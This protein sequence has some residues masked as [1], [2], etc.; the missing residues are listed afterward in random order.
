[1]STRMFHTPV[2][3][4][5]ARWRGVRAVAIARD[6]GIDMSVAEARVAVLTTEDLSRWVTVATR[7]RGPA[8]AAAADLALGWTDEGGE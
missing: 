7:H 4:D 2:D 8:G 5:A 3:A 6:L 1:M